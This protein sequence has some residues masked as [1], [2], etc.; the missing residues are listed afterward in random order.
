[1]NGGTTITK[2]K[3]GH[4]GTRIT[5]QNVIV[6]HDCPHP[7]GTWHIEDT[8]EMGHTLTSKPIF[9]SKY[10]YLILLSILECKSHTHK[11][12]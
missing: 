4:K 11:Y 2:T 10:K 3:R 12:L 8:G 1:M 5:Q 7:E 9:I 6:S